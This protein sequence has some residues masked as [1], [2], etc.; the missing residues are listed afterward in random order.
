MEISD[1]DTKKLITVVAGETNN[2]TPPTFSGTGTTQDPLRFLE[3]FEKVSKW[4]NWRTDERRKET[5]LLCLTGHA[6]RWVKNHLMKDLDAFKKLA[7]DNNTTECLLGKFKLQYITEDWYEIYTKQYEDRVQAAE[8]TPT[9]YMEVKRYLFQRGGPDCKDMSDKQQVRLIMKGLLPQVKTFCEKK[10]KDPFN[11]EA[12]KNMDSLE[13][14]EKLLK[15]AESCLYEDKKV[16]ALQSIQESEVGSPVLSVMRRNGNTNT[17][18]GYD[19]NQN[20]RKQYDT[21]NT[22]SGKSQNGYS[23]FEKLVLE[24]LNK[25]D[26]IENDFAVLRD[27]VD[28]LEKGQNTKIGV[29]APHQSNGHFLRCYNC[30]GYGHF[31]RECNSGCNSCEKGGHSAAACPKRPAPTNVAH[32]NNKKVNV[33]EGQ[34]FQ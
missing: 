16:L 30:E 9:E 23:D 10:L 25:L 8:E 11:S 28:L 19:R 18:N 5:F 2:R 26:V 21:R 29:T 7:Y 1:T 4:N 14:L 20:E 6:E 17:N 22:N 24:K 27:R 15:W 32:D 33:V 12:K 13:G 31:A 3:E 34:D